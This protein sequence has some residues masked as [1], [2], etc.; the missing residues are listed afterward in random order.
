MHKISKSIDKKKKTYLSFAVIFNLLYLG[1]FKYSDF[2]IDNYNIVFNTNITHLNIPFP[3]ALSF[4]TFQTIAFLIDVYDEALDHFNFKKF[5]IFI[6][7]FPQ[8]IAGPIV[9]FNNMLSQFE[10][11]N[12]KKAKIDNISI[13]SIVFNWRNKK[14]FIANYI[15]IFV[16]QGFS[17]SI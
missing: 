10:N 2:F 17:S 13:G 15:S 8:L 4:V 7:F 6:I 11:E 1:F 12:N 16:D 14:T 3:L 5:S 9:R